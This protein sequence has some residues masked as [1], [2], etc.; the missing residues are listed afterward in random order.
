MNPD[1]TIGS[2]D[3]EVTAKAKRR[4]FCAEYKLRILREADALA[5]TGGV[6]ELLRRE[7]LYCSHLSAWGRERERGELE[8]LGAKKR[9]RKADPDRAPRKKNARLA[10]QVARL[11][12]RL[13]QAEAII[14]VQKKWPRCGGSP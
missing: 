13:E 1:S 2:P 12:K 8:E 4:R 3:P 9:G 11:E 14:D 6:G 10:R 7:G 5:E